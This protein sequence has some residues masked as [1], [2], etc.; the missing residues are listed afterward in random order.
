MIATLIGCGFR[1][2]EL[3]SLDLESVQLREDHGLWRIL[4][5]R[6][7]TFARCRFRSGSNEQ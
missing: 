7:V 4:S 2:G 5:A 3:Q 6:R 1:R